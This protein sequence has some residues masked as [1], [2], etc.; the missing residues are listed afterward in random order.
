[1]SMDAY[2]DMVNNQAW[3]KGAYA[4]GSACGVCERC[5]RERIKLYY[6]RKITI[7]GHEAAIDYYKKLRYVDV[8]TNKQPPRR[9]VLQD[10]VI[11][12]TCMQQS[13]LI[14]A[15][16][17]PDGIKKDHPVKVLLRWFRRCVLL[18]AFTRSVIDDPYAP[19]GGSFTGP[20]DNGICT[21]LDDAFELYLKSVDELPHHFQLH[22]MHAAEIIGYKHPNIEIRKWWAGVYYSIVNDAHLYPESME[23]MDER[24]GDNE[25]AWRAREEVT[26]Q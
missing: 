14:T 11:A 13:V 20:V 8:I 12:L 15:V 23:Q 17:G 22:F 1:M 24:L 26:A 18:S 4:L 3:C 7:D 5:K 9:S 10:W 19:G 2:M 6:D 25:A 16:R 21:N